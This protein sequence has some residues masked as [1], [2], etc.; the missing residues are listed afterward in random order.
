MSVPTPKSASSYVR[1]D[2]PEV[3]VAR[4]GRIIVREVVY[5]TIDAALKEG[6]E[7][8]GEAASSSV[9]ALNSIRSGFASLVDSDPKLAWKLIEGLL[10]G[11]NECVI[12]QLICRPH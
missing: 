9:S 3:P 7:L 8:T 5:P 1:N 4:L 11:I 2:D 12:F 10:H 6:S